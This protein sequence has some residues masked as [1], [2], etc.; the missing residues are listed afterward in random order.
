MEAEYV[1]M[2]E[3]LNDLKFIY[4]SLKYL[5]MKVN[6]PMILLIDNI[7]VIEMLDVKT[8]KCRTKHVDTSNHWIREFIDND[9]VKVK[10]MKLEDNTSD[11]CKKSSC[12]ATSETFREA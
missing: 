12:Q 1:S 4:M 5:Q 10:Y 6:L 7:G 9:L 11:I 3:G 2:S 8:N